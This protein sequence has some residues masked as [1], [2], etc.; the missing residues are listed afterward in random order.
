MININGNS[1]TIEQLFQAGCKKQPVQLDGSGMQ[2]LVQGREWLESIYH[3]G[4]PVYGINTGFGVF[5]DN[6]IGE[7][8]SAQLS[9]NLI[10]SH[11]VAMGE[12]MDSETVR[13]AM[14]VR[15]NALAIGNSGIRPEIVTTLLGML[16]ADVV[17]IIPSK[18]SLGSSGDLCFLSELALVLSTDEN[19]R[20]EESGWVWYQGE[21][22]RGKTGMAKAGLTRYILGPKEGLALINGA[23]FSAAL[24]GLVIRKTKYLLDVAIVNA[25]MVLEALKGCTDAFDARIHQVRRHAGQCQIADLMNKYIVGSSLV[26]SGGR[27]QDAYTLRCVP[28]I[29]GPVLETLRF[30]SGQIMTEINSA[31]DNP[32][33]FDD[34]TS[35]SGGNFH[36]EIIAMA[37]DYLGIAAAEAG[38]LSERRV[39]RLLDSHL[40]YGLPPMLVDGFEKVGLNSGL[41]IP[42]YTMTSLAL[43]NQHLANSDSVHSLPTSASQE[44][45]N[46]NSWF[47][48][49]HASEIVNNLET[50]L[51][52]ELFTVCR[53]IKLRFKEVPSAKLGKGCQQIYDQIEPLVPLTGEDQYW[54][55]SLDAF[56]G[57][58]KEQSIHLENELITQI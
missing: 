57:L 30:V 14:L 53:A 47:A 2:A 38:A 45:V 42:H 55:S 28:Q 36:G 13:A 23:T 50:L 35:F 32:L 12:P 31:T 1:L 16:N 6:H 21:T 41:M 7:K 40:N 4:K 10:L 56:K 54:K 51:A 48:A 39:F 49:V 24:A 9:R 22:L 46:A 11:S 5:A 33:I 37:M 29:L 25:A 17:P 18:G 20:E 34:Y 43:E 15:A 8:N 58:L 44:D 27:V 26:N 52:I 19:D 3:R